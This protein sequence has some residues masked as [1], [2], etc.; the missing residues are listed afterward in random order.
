MTKA[1]RKLFDAIKEKGGMLR[2][3]FVD[4]YKS[5][6]ILRRQVNR[7]DKMVEKGFLEVVD[8]DSLSGVTYRIR[9]EAR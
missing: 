9:K 4:Y 8:D 7:L 2:L 5:K 6:P 3:L 1:E